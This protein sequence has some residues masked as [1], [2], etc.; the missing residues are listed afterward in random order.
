MWARMGSN[1]DSP[2]HERSTV[3]SQVFTHTWGLRVH[4]DSRH[5]LAPTQTQPCVHHRTD[6]L[7]PQDVRTHT[8]SSPSAHGPQPR[9][10]H[11]DPDAH[12][13]TPAR[14][15]LCWTQPRTRPPPAA[16]RTHRGRRRRPAPSSP[17]S[18]GA[19]SGA[20]TGHRTPLTATGTAQQVTR[21]DP[22]SGEGPPPRCRRTEPGA[23]GRD[24]APARG[25]GGE[26]NF[27][28]GPGVSGSSRG[29]R[30]AVL[31]GALTAF[32]QRWVRNGRGAESGV[33]AAGATHQWARAGAGGGQAEH[34]AC[35]VGE[36]GERRLRSAAGDGEGRDA[37]GEGWARLGETALLAAGQRGAAA[38]LLGRRTSGRPAVL[39][40]ASCCLC[41]VRGTHRV[42]ALQVLLVRDTGTATRNTG[43]R[44]PNGAVEQHS[45]AL[46]DCGSHKGAGKPLPGRERFPEGTVSADPPSYSCCRV[47]HE[48]AALSQHSPT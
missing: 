9:P 36:S 41:P 18:P 20:G 23:A 45:G 30:G 21:T 29:H 25:D 33:G 4:S 32:R 27:G 22:G 38:G 14:T 15:W 11:A 48:N 31:P 40:P 24:A 39:G 7:S 47:L 28:T 13:P 19:H 6:T 26:S 12:R 43:T 17:R 1:T 3:H 5:T 46:P 2:A 8:R 10:A 34:R 16:P 42:S 37:P 44:F 35:A